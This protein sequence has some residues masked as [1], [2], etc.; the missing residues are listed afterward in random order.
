MEPKVIKT[1]AEY[2]AALAHVAGLMDA[3]PGSPREEELDLFSLLVEQYEREHHPVP[4][5]DPIEA[6]K[7]RMEQA[8]LTRA[9]L[10]PYLGSASRVSEVLN[11]KRPL[12]LAMIRHLSQGLGI[13]AEV[14]LQAP[15]AP[16]AAPHYDA[17]YGGQNDQRID[18]RALEA[19]QARALALAS[20][21]TL[22]AFGETALDE[23]FLRKVVRLSAYPGGPRLAPDLLGGLGI[24]F[25]ILANLPNTHLDGAAF[26]APWGR[27]VVAMTLRYDRLDNFW[28]TLLH[29]LAH[30]E[31]HLRPGG[32]VFFDDTSASSGEASDPRETEADARARTLLIPAEIWARAGVKIAGGSPADVIRLAEELEVSPA[33]VAGRARSERQDYAL[34]SELIGS[35]RVAE[36]FEGYGRAA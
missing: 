30:V 13:P 28:F 15:P 16:D 18:F 35:K 2:A 34:F 24:H 20:E 31:L 8:G 11:R 5:P 17:V 33:I 32:P 25:V 36:C 9:D 19:W 23:R 10:I 7:F 14:L 22:P 26:M 29:E 6:V 27:P 1:E 3:E 4:L 21:Q 12:S